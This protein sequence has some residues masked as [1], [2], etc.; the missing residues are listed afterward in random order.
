M[1]DWLKNLFCIFKEG[2]PSGNLPSPR[3]AIDRDDI[4][5]DRE[6]RTLTIKN[7]EPEVVIETVLNTNSME[8]AIDIGHIVVRSNNPK[9]LDDIGVGDVIVWLNS[10]GSYIIHPVAAIGNDGEWYC[11]TQGW[12]IPR[13]D[14]VRI[15]K[16]NIVDVA[17]LVIWSKGKGGS[18]AP[19]G[20]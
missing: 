8:R 20:D 6:S 16:S 19:P 4:S 1:F 7:I 5:Y 17:L 18:A 15:R 12:N 3:V 10:D 9:Y 2:G 11:E 14:G 13:R